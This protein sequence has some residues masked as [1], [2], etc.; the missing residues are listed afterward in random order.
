M[1]SLGLD[2][3]G[4][5]LIVVGGVWIDPGVRHLE[6][7]LHDRLAYVDVGDPDTACVVAGGASI[8]APRVSSPRGD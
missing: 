6:G 7:Q 8:L 3:V 4:A 5:L 2:S 1:R